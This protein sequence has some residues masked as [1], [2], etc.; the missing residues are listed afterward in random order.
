VIWVHCGDNTEVATTLSL[1]NRLIEH[2]DA[3]DILL[4]C[5][6]H[7]LTAFDALPKDVRRVEIPID[8]PA[9]TRAFLDDWGPAFLIWNGGALRPALLRKVERAV[10]SATLI[11]A[12]NAGLVPGGS[13]WM[14]GATRSA[15]SAFAKIFTADGATAT[16]L[17]R[18]GVPDEKIEATGPILEE[19]IALPHNQYE[20]T[21]MAEALGTRPVWL[22]ANVADREIV[23]MTAAH[24]AASRKNHRLL[25]VLTPRNIDNGVKAAQTLRDAGFNVGVR[26]DGDD[27]EAEHQAYIADLPNELG[28]WYRLVPLTY[29]GGTMT[30]DGAT[31]P[32]E[33]I[34][35]GS[36]VIHG[37]HKAPHETRFDRLSTVQACREVRS[38][39]ELGIA[40]SVLV[41][42]EQTA[43]MAVAG[44]E[45]ITQ[46]ADKINQLVNTALEAAG[47]R[48][49]DT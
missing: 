7:N 9:K 21:V 35:L 39:S 24:M 10:I 32:F 14:P 37:P 34:M 31:S 29:M 4:T 22:A 38:A 15:V 25:M 17:T 28:L 41:S 49:A 42:P 33:P 18:S 43:R 11:N 13:R 19:P 12:K 20:L 5:E 48:T 23:D 2:S 26:S 45:E 36:A 6:A 46:N 47:H 1:V 3:T 8:T 16:R 40:I 30:N 27:P 44:W